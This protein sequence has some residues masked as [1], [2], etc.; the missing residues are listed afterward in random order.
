MLLLLHVYIL[1][2]SIG[3]IRWQY[4]HLL[5]QLGSRIIGYPLRHVVLVLPLSGGSN[6]SRVF[7]IQHI[8]DVHS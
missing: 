8:G 4:W 1:E 3:V 2:W 6:G 5:L 7:S